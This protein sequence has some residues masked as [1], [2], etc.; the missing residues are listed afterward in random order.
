MSIQ[1]LLSRSFRVRLTVGALA[2]LIAGCCWISQ[3]ELGEIPESMW[4]PLIDGDRDPYD[5]SPEWETPRVFA[6]GLSMEPSGFRVCDVREV[7]F[8]TPIGFSVARDEGWIVRR[9]RGLLGQRLVTARYRTSLDVM[10][11]QGARWM[12]FYHVRE[13]AGE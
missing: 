3:S 2:L 1:G 7:D 12:R 11:L 10:E 9:L 6:N 8:N 13:T 4:L 5:W